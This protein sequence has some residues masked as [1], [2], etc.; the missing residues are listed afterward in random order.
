MCVRVCRPP[1][2][3]SSSWLVSCE[4]THTGGTHCWKCASFT[5]MTKCRWHVKNAT[6]AWLHFTTVIS[7]IKTHVRPDSCTLRNMPQYSLSQPYCANYQQKHKDG[8]RWILLCPQPSQPKWAQ[9]SLYKTSTLR[10]REKCCISSENVFCIRVVPSL[11]YF[12]C[13]PKSRETY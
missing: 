13:S 7:A 10:R 5:A 8:H 12:L 9:A 6:G 1:R 11:Y 4:L 2:P 3:Q